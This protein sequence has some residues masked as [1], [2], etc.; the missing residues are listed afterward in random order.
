MKGTYPIIINNKNLT[1]YC[2]DF[3][4]R[5]EDELILF[6]EVDFDSMGINLK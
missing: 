6:V 2:P 5:T 4:I 1:V 3:D